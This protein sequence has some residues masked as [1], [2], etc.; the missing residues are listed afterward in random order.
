M[1][2]ECLIENKDYQIVVNNRDLSLLQ[3]V[4]PKRIF[5]VIWLKF[6]SLSQRKRPILLESDVDFF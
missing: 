3:Y 4:D 2:E 1:I 5:L 6:K